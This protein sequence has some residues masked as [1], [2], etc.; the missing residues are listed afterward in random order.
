MKYDEMMKRFRDNGFD[1]ERKMF[2]FYGTFPDV[3]DFVKNKEGIWEKHQM[4]EKSPGESV[5][6]YACEEDMVKE[7]LHHVYNESKWN[8]DY[9]ARGHK[10]ANVDLESYTAAME[11]FDKGV[12]KDVLPES[13]TRKESS[14]HSDLVKVA[15]VAALGISALLTLWKKKKE[16]L[17][18]VSGILIHAERDSVCMGDDVMAPNAQDVRFDNNMMV[19]ELMKWVVEYVPAMKN[20]EWDILC[21]STMIGKLISGEDCIYRS[22]L[23][24][25]DIA[26]SELP[27]TKIFCR[28]KR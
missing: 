7:I 17:P 10:A 6:P 1:L 20:Y 27:D 12:F 18:A 15:G 5:Y 23:M 4:R 8:L 14:D 2:I 3:T 24:I 19:S 28:I 13:Y 25:N 21:N 26:I 16:N 11:V 22:E 9:V